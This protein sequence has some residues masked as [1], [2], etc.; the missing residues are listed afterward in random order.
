MNFK[1]F[2]YTTRFKKYN[3]FK[4]F[5]RYIEFKFKNLIYNFLIIF[6]FKKRNKNYIDLNNYQDSRYINFLIYSLK[7]NFHFIYKKNENT[8]L[9]LKKIG[10]LNFFKHTCDKNQIKNQKKIIKINFNQNLKNNG[11]EINSDYF[12]ILKKNKLKDYF[13]MPYYMYPEVYNYDYK[14]FNNQVLPFKFRIFFSGGMFQEVY[15]K[16]KWR[17]N[18]QDLLNRIDVINLIIKEFKNE[19]FFI[20]K[21]SDLKTEKIFKKKIIFCLHDKMLSKKKYIL[22]FK[23]NY[24]MISQSA[25]NLSCP[26]V[27][28]PLCHHLIEGIKFGSIPITSCA[29]LIV[30]KLDEEICLKYDNAES[31]LNSI[32]KALKMN[33]EN[34][35][36]KRLKLKKFYYKNLSPDSFKDKFLNNLKMSKPKKILVCDDHESVKL[37]KKIKV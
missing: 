37:Y 31:L 20:Q 22:S 19:I 12:S 7:N 2:C 23:E 24:K 16:F 26:G 15:S 9:L 3:K 1:Q 10:L 13:V 29:D 6:N 17:I 28:M 4:I 25:F 18:D 21:K 34:I 27:V 30:P 11:L 36:E 8:I 35:N 5:L 33:K 14:K 32:Y